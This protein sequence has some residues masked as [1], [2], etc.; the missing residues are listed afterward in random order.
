MNEMFI[1]QAIVPVGAGATK[2]TPP[3]NAG[4]TLKIATLRR[5]PLSLGKRSER[6]WYPRCVIAGTAL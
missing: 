3:I 2:E 4:W 6:D 1:Q 5:G